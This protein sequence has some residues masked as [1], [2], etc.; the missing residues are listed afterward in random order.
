MVNLSTFTIPSDYVLKFN[1]KNKKINDLI[2]ENM[3]EIE[4]NRMMKCLWA[5]NSVNYLEGIAKGTT[6]VDS[7]G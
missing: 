7:F 2:G 1:V 4:E 3:V 6:F 5:A